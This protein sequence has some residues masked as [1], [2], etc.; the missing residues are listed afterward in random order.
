VYAQ[1]TEKCAHRL[2]PSQVRQRASKVLSTTD[3][4]HKRERRGYAGLR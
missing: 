1:L 4:E 3:G 2:T